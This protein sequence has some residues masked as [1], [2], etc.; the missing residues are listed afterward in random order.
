MDKF[1]EF[2]RLLELK[3]KTKQ[4]MSDKGYTNFEMA[5]KLYITPQYLS[6]LLNYSITAEIYILEKMYK[7]MS[8][9]EQLKPE[10]EFDA[11]LVEQRITRIEMN[12]TSFAK[13]LPKYYTYATVRRVIRERYPSKDYELLKEILST[14]ERLEKQYAQKRKKL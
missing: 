8:K 2:E 1:K 13:E 3:A 4:L 9:F 14:L 5:K 10:I 12:I 6:R 11:N 7:K